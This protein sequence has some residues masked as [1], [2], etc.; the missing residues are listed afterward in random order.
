VLY[1]GEHN[2]SMKKNAGNF[3]SSHI[4]RSKFSMGLFWIDLGDNNKS[5]LKTIE[6]SFL[7]YT[8]SKGERT[9]T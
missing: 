6:L 9:K 2:K 5:I 3:G 4:R 8:S 1:I 7:Q